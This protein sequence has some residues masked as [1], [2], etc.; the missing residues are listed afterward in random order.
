MLWFASWTHPAP[1]FSAG[2]DGLEVGGHQVLPASARD[3]HSGAICPQPAVTGP[4]AIK[5]HASTEIFVPAIS[6]GLL[7]HCSVSSV[8]QSHL[9]RGAWS[10]VNKWIFQVTSNANA[11]KARAIE[12]LSISPRQPAACPRVAENTQA[13]RSSRR[14]QLGKNLDS[15]SRFHLEIL[16]TFPSSASQRAH[17]VWRRRQ[18][19]ENGCGSMLRALAH[20]RRLCYSGLNLETFHN[21]SGGALCEKDRGPSRDAAGS[22]RTLCCSRLQAADQPGRCSRTDSYC[23]RKARG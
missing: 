13:G 7:L 15:Q 11:I 2:V 6:T 3:D 14:S 18:Y 21:R 22:R 1:T 23:R 17:L 10:A 16:I 5:L 4:V 9:T 19:G 12:A 8:R 20:I